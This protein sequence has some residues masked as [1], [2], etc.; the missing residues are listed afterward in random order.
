M[1]RSRFF[2]LRKVTAVPQTRDS[3]ELIG[4][5]PPCVST[6]QQTSHT[7]WSRYCV[8]DTLKPWGSTVFTRPR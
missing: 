3:I 7:G 6:H 5:A 1:G 4:Y 2:R 8:T